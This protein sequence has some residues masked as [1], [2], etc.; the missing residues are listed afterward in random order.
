MNI[1]LRA[2]RDV[3]LVQIERKGPYCRNTLSQWL[4]WHVQDSSRQSAKSP[5]KMIADR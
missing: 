4:L 1:E 2:S 3:L 5:M